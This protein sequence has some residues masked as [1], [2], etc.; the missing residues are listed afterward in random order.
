LGQAYA[1]AN[2]LTRKE[3]VASRIL[4]VPIINWIYETLQQDDN[5]RIAEEFFLDDLQ[6]D[7]GDFAKEQLDVAIQWGRHAELF[8]FDDKTDE[9]YLES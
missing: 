5:Q 7:F 6:A 4:R 1:D 2:I 3:L 8:A 9:L